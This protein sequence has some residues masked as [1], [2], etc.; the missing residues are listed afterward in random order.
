MKE[1]IDKFIAFL[2]TLW[3]RLTDRTQLLSDRAD[4][5][6]VRV[7]DSIREWIGSI[8]EHL[9][10]NDFIVTTGRRSEHVKSSDFAI[11]LAEELKR[12]GKL[13][14]IIR[15]DGTELEFYRR[16]LA[17]TPAEH[18]HEVP[19]SEEEVKV[20]EEATGNR[21]RILAVVSAD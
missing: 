1:W 6:L 8:A 19:M 17:D 10:V 15:D 9:E 18:V 4:P 21:E 5:L 13:L 12:R 11:E 20:W 14:S 2:R 7:I 3:G 16:A